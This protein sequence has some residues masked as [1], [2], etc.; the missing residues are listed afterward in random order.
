MFTDYIHVWEEVPSLSPTSAFCEYDSVLIFSNNNAQSVDYYLNDSI[1][2]SSNAPSYNYQNI[3]EG[4]TI[5]VAYHLNSGCTLYSDSIIFELVDVEGGVTQND[6]Q[7][8]AIANG[9][10]YQWIDCEN[11]NSIILG[12]TDQ[13]FVPLMDGEYAVEVIENGC[14]DTSECFVFELNGLDENELE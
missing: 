3:S 10:I 2:N 14:K 9:A 1:V 12:A 8:S 4:D 6:I 7:L 13:I 5:H 11:N